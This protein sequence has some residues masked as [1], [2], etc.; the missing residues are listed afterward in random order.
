MPEVVAR[1]ITLTDYRATAVT[2]GAG[3]QQAGEYV[4]HLPAQ[5]LRSSVSRQPAN[6]R[7]VNI[8][9]SGDLSQGFPAGFL[10][11]VRRQLGL[12]AEP[13]ALGLGT[14]AALAS[15]LTDQLAL[16]LR[17]RR[18]QGREQPPLR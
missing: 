16:K 14:L 11:L 9:G 7:L 12:A 15:A 2:G 5:P 3:G 18:E 13:H 17:N 1:E 10:T 8:V 6:H 4:S